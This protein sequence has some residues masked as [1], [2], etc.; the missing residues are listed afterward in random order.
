M[1]T[2]RSL[3]PRRLHVIGE[4][5]AEL[6]DV[7]AQAAILVVNID[8]DGMDAEMGAWWGR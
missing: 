8:I 2:R 6:V 4:V 7:E 3:G 1:A 5:E